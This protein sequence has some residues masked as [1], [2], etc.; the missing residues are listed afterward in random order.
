MMKA[1]A[2][3]S[4]ASADTVKTIIDTLQVPMSAKSIVGI[5]C[6]AAGGGLTTLE[7]ISGIL[8][9]ES[10]DISLAPM[11]LPL[12]I[13]IPLASGAIAHSPR[14]FPANIPV[15]G[16]EKISGYVTMDAALT[17]NNKCR[18]GFIYET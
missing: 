4:T 7:S 8:E 11:Q 12:D 13:I 6:Y 2:S 9:L 5:W 10:P 1:Q 15:H 16:G 17:I 3:A 14:I 18:F